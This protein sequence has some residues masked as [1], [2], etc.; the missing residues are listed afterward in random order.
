MQDKNKDSRRSFLQHSS[1]ILL[2]AITFNGLNTNLF[3]QE[4]KKTNDSIKTHTNKGKNMNTLTQ[5]AKQNLQRFFGTSKLEKE[6][7]EFFTNYANFAFDEVWQKSDLDEKERF[8]L[9]LASL[10]AIPANKEFEAML[11]AAIN[12]KVN[13]I[14]IKEVIYQATAYVGMAKIAD[15]LELTNKIFKQKGI[16]L[17]LTTQG[18]T[19]MENRRQKGFDIQK[20]IFGESIEKSYANTPNHRKHI[21][22]FLSANCFGDYYTRNGLSLKLRELA[23]FVYLI[24]MGDTQMQVKAHIQ[25]NLN[26]GNDKNKLIAVVTALIP[27]IGYPR[28]LN[29]LNAIDEVKN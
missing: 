7:L 19:T 27:Y 28:A 25:G 29:A 26:I 4:S 10:L 9:I 18:T 13:P 12:A 17:P 24:S 21:N 23:T 3:A 14:A 8:L 22:E 20:A 2:T 5:K 16:K 6:D 11:N 15:I 1:K